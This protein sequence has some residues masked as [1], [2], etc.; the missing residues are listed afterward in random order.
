MNELNEIL[1]VTSL[2]K[3]I[4]TISLLKHRNMIVQNLKELVFNSVYKTNERDHIQKI[5][6]DNF[7]LFGEQY[8]LVTKDEPFQNS[9]EKYITL[10]DGK[11][12]VSKMDSNYKNKRLDIFMCK[13]RKEGK[14]IHNII[15]ELKNPKIKIG[16]KEYFQVDEYKRAVLSDAEFKST[17]ALWEIH[18]VGVDFARD[19]VIESFIESNKNHGEKNLVLNADG[20]KIYAKRWADIFDEFELTHDFLNEKLELEKKALIMNH[21]NVV[22]KEA[23]IEYASWL[24]KIK[25][26]V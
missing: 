20:F 18:L 21:E 25:G 6:E 7:W 17:H 3:V 15:A 4:N 1:Q 10:L 26:L 8:N 19:G 11:K 16:K 14:R 5:V 22:I 9:L 24:I 23:R 2:S 12:K 13:K